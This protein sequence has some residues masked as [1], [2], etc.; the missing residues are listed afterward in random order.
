MLYF[1]PKY[2]GAWQYANHF[3]NSTIRAKHLSGNCWKEGVIHAESYRR[4]AKT[5][6][7]KQ[8]LSYEAKFRIDE[9]NKTIKF[10]EALREDASGMQAGG[11][12]QVETYSTGKSGAREGSIQQQSD[13][14]GKKYS[15]SFDFKTVRETIESIAQ[16]SG[17]SFVYQITSLG[18]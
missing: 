2:N 1:T 12:F 5:F 18:L 15:Y 13:Q 11:G 10:T 4:G 17:Y 16:K 3:R 6:L 9:A 8:K 7:S 14:F